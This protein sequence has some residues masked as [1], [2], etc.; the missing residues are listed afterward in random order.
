[1]SIEIPLGLNRKPPRR[2]LAPLRETIAQLK[3]GDVVT[4]TIHKGVYG[5]FTITGAVRRTLTD[6]QWVLASWYLNTGENP[7]DGLL[8]LEILQPA[9]GHVVAEK[10]TAE[11]VGPE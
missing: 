10:V 3:Q 4:A 9:D 2:T 5:T 11:N 6:T 8:A 7:T 1:M